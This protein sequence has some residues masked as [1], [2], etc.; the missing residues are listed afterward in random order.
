MK[1]QIDAVRVGGN[2]VELRHGE[3]VL[4]TISAHNGYVEYYI[5]IEERRLKAEMARP[6]PCLCCGI[7]IRSEGPHHRLCNDC[8]ARS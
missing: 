6:R 5:G 3:R 4:R 7:E 2:R 1:L 8:R